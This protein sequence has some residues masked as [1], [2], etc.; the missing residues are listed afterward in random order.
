M[1]LFTAEPN[2]C[3]KSVKA[4][5]GPCITFVNEEDP[6]PPAPQPS[7]KLLKPQHNIVQLQHHQIGFAFTSQRITLYQ[8]V[9]L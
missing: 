9:G 6:H 7:P 4:S 5:A 1:A 8:E 2:L 3:K